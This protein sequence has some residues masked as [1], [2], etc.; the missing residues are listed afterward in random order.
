MPDVVSVLLRL[1]FLRNKVV[2]LDHASRSEF[3]GFLTL[4]RV[5]HVVMIV[6]EKQGEARVAVLGVEEKRQIT[7]VIASSMDGDLLPLQ[8]IFA[9][10]LSAHAL[11][12]EIAGLR[13]QSGAGQ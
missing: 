4:L 10:K 7:A 12:A 2:R 9:A 11:A 1:V 8:L 5:P 6:N 13:A 3:D